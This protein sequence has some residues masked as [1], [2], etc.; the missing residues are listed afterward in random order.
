MKPDKPAPKSRRRGKLSSQ[1]QSLANDSEREHSELVRPLTSLDNELKRK[2]RD[3]PKNVGLKLMVEY[4][5]RVTR[6]RITVS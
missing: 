6:G 2:G 4:E 1:Q 3:K 5:P